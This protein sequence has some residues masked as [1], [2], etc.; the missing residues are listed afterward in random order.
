MK[1][2]AYFLLHK[3]QKPLFQNNCNKMQKYSVLFWLRVFYQYF[4]D[5]QL[6]CSEE[7]S[8]SLQ[9]GLHAGNKLLRN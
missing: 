3:F 5:L 8:D 7:S 1:T 2:Q 6:L 9:F 4:F